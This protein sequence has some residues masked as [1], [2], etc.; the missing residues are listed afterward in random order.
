MNWLPRITSF[1]LVY[2]VKYFEI[3]LLELMATNFSPSSGV[4]CFKQIPKYQP[5]EQYRAI[6]ALLLMA[7]DL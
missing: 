5:V 2:L 6:M 1:T 7:Y 4:L 3:F